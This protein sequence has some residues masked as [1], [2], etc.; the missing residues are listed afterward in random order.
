MVAFDVQPDG[1]LTNERQ[2]ASAGGDGST[3]DAEGRVYTSA[4]PWIAVIA[5]DGKLLGT[6]PVPTDDIISLAFSGP[7]KKTLYG[8]ANNQQYDEIFKIEM[9][10][11]GYKGRA[12]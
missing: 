12:K 1:S 5:P 2:F 10:A 9:I 4:C 11:Q 6:I 8:V 7:D 3:I